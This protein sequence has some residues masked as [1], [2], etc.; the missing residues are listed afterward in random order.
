MDTEDDGNNTWKK[1]LTVAGSSS[2]DGGSSVRQRTVVSSSN[3][4]SPQAIENS[5][6]LGCYLRRFFVG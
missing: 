1:N 5:F 3:P 6:Q 4:V 2:K